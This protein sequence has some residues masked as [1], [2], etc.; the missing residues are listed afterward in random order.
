MLYLSNEHRLLFNLVFVLDYT[1]YQF[2]AG[3]FGLAGQ[4]AH[5]NK[6]AQFSAELLPDFCMECLTSYGLTV[7]GRARQGCHQC[8]KEYTMDSR[9]YKRKVV[10]DLITQSRHDYLLCMAYRRYIYAND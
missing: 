4:S 7:G 9:M 6:H 10:W 3:I 5:F 2:L 1:D 8:N